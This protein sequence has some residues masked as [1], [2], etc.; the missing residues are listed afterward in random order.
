MWPGYHKLVFR[1]QCW[2][3]QMD[4]QDI[5]EYALVISLI[6]LL[7]TVSNRA[8]ANVVSTA[9]SNVATQFSATV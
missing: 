5:V 7:I 1:L 3:S 4:G 9:F 6:A 8:V 2:M